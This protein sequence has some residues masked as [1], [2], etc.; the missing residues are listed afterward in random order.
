MCVMVDGTTAVETLLAYAR[1][2][3]SMA[4]DAFNTEIADELRKLAAEC[5]RAALAMSGDTGRGATL[6]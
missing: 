4:D 5:T 6:H 3:R 1:R 2:C